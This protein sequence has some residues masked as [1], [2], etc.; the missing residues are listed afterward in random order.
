MNEVHFGATMDPGLLGIFKAKVPSPATFRSLILE[1][2]RFTA[3][4]ALREG[5]V[6]ALGGREEAMKFIQDRELVKKGDSGVLAGLKEEMYKDQ[7]AALSSTQTSAEWHAALGAK[8]QNRSE[9]RERRIE[10]AS[11]KAGESKL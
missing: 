6:D 10:T 7:L 5:L 9:E 11:S 3:Q 8:L 2:H 1:G 4:Q